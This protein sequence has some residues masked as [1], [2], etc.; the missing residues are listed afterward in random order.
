MGLFTSQN[1][2]KRHPGDLVESRPGKGSRF[3]IRFPMN[4]LETKQ[5]PMPVDRS[6]A[7]P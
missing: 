3:I 7:S 4:L 2:L 1:I 5:S 6:A